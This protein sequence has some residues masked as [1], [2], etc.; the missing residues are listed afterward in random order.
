MVIAIGDDYMTTYLFAETLPAGIPE[1]V[2]PW[3][4]IGRLQKENDSDD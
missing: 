4:K 3:E 1:A 2:L